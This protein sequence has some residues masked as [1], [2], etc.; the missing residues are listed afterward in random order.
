STRMNQWPHK[1]S[2]AIPF[3]FA[4]FSP[5]ADSDQRLSSF[6]FAPGSSLV[7]SDGDRISRRSSCL[8]PFSKK[9]Q[10]SHIIRHP[11]TSNEVFASPQRETP[12]TISNWS[13]E[14]WLLNGSTIKAQ[15]SGRSPHHFISDTEI[16][17]DSNWRA[18]RYGLFRRRAGRKELVGTTHTFFF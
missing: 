2:T 15:C 14:Y 4:V 13:K 7:F 3:E 9:S 11:Q 5:S 1:L 10:K 6:N 8:L 16:G 17:L 12:A 18:E